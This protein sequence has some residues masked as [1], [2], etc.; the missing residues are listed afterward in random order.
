M[1][2]L[3]FFALIALLTSCWPSSVS[4]VDTGSMPE[5][6]KTFSIKTLENNAPNTPISYAATLSEAIKDGIQNNTR[7]LLNPTTGKGEVYI[8]GVISGYS[9]VPVALQEGDNAQKNRLTITTSYTIY[10]SAPKEDQIT[11][12]SSRF[13]DYDSNTDLGSVEAT[14]LEEINT[15]IVQ[16]VI[17]KLLSNW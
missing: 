15:Q 11:L 5:E 4:F 10:I 14:L 6:W 16:D 8:E 7:L 12:T 13:V 1:K 3:S 2:Y 17:N 9:V